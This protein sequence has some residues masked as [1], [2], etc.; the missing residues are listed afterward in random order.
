MKEDQTSPDETKAV[1]MYLVCFLSRTEGGILHFYLI[2]IN[3]NML[4]NVSFNDLKRYY[5]Y[6]QTFAISQRHCR[7]EVSQKLQANL[8]DLWVAR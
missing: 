5:K 1:G 3:R 8:F 2:S 7:S 4:A 6:S